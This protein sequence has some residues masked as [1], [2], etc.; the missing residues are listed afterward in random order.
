MIL[1][2]LRKAITV[3]RRILHISSNVFASPKS[4]KHLGLGHQPTNS[5]GIDKR[6]QEFTRR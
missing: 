2:K 6:T 3:V 5:H 1:S 4:P